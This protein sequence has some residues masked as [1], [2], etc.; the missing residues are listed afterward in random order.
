MALIEG[1]YKDETLDGT[2]G[3]DEIYGYGGNDIL[4]GNGSADTLVGGSGTDTLTGGAGSDS[5][6]YDSREFGVDT[7]TDFQQGT[8]KINVSGLN[9]GDFATLQRFIENDSNGDAVITLMHRGYLEKIVLTGV[10]AAS[11]NASS[12]QFNTSSTNLVVN[13]TYDDDVLFGGNGNDTLSGAG[14]EDTLSGGAGADT[15]N[16]GSGNDTLIGGTGVDSFK[17]DTREFGVDTITDFQQGTD[18]IDVSGL[19]VGD[20]ATLQRFIENDSNG[21]A[22]I[23]LTH[24]G[25]IEKIVLTGV[26]AASLNASSFQFNTST[27]NLVVNGTYDDDV[28]F[29]GNGNDTLNGAGGADTLSGGAGADTL[30]GGGANDTLIG[31]VGADLFKYDSREFGVDIVIDF[32]QGTDKID[33]SG[34][35]VGDFTTLQRFISSDIAGNALINLGHRGYTEQIV[36]I[37]ISASS[38]NANSFKYNVG[39]ANLTVNGTYDDDVLFGGNA[40]DTINGA[41]GT[42]TLSGGAGADTLVGGAGADILIGGA[43]ADSFKYDSR[44]FGVDTITDFQQGTDK[45]DVSG[46]NVGDFA[47]LQRFIST[48]INGNAII[49]LG[50]RGYAEQIVLTG[51]SASSLNANSFK[52]NVGTA[53]L[54][55]NGTYDNDVLF[56]GNANDTL[57]GGNGADTLSGGAGADALSGGSGNDV[58]IGG[59]GIDT[60]VGGLNND[61]YYVDN[62]GDVITESNGEGTDKIFSSVSYSLAG[63]YVETLELT[64]SS[65]INAT[66]NSQANTLIGNSGNNILNGGTGIDVLEGGLGNDTYYVDNLSDVVTELDGQG[67]DKIYSSVSYILGSNTYV[68]TLEL[69][70]SGNNNL[71]G[72]SRS[73]TL[74]GNSGSNVLDGKESAD[75][76]IGGL[77][78]DTYYVNTIN[79]V[80]TELDGQGADK[81]YSSVSYILGSNTYVETL[82]LTGSGNNSLTGNGR[83][84]TLIGNSGSNILAGLTGNDKIT[85]NSGSDTAL[86]K[87]LTDNSATGGNGS[88]TWTDFTV[89]DTT[90]NINADKIDISALLVD[91]SGDNTISALEPYL[92]VNNSGGNTTVLIDR[93]GAGSTYSDTLLLTLTGLTTNLNDLI[94]NHQILI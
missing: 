87:L 39:S 14:G 63:R 47:T 53:N 94:N 32:Q 25:Y 1:T 21:D 31:G 92:T 16:G 35:N 90:S 91:Y 67:A 61:T 41:G 81:I 20:F 85:G 9:V 28:L 15:L 69:T 46:L 4:K 48:D 89:G 82:E 38:L 43:G 73:N 2:S 45:I 77:G 18:K 5:F 11:L 65:A 50:Y 66:G 55:V 22:V 10:S 80:V 7:I 51:V 60:M 86:Y 78:N 24:R 70:G 44:E 37:G 52:Y 23:T 79:D 56:G 49:T 75:T 74:I 59:A 93:D 30:I 3:Q 88:D 26:S 12:F 68:E 8:D 6:K 57:N 34:L 19:N 42:D 58:L 76:M 27:T 54:T 72:N 64:G 83:S 33:V 84:N 62:V 71:T 17:Y 40:N 29:G 13:G 36:L